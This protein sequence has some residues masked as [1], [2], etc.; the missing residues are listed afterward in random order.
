MKYLIDTDRVADYLKG[1]AQSVALLED[2]APDG[3]GISLITYGE[4]YDGIYA[5]RDPQTHERAFQNFLRAVLVVSLNRTILRRF[6]RIR[7]ELRRKGQLI[8]DPDILIA[9]TALCHDLVLVTRN[10]KDFSRVPDLS[11]YQEG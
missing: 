1:V 5:G 4:I 11:L 7:G 6:A 3:L 2:L 8:G 9:A 10:R